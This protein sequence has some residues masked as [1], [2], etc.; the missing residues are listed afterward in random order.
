MSPRIVIATAASDWTGTAVAS[1]YSALANGV[2]VPVHVT[3]PPSSPG[4]ISS[5]L[6]PLGTTTFVLTVTPQAGTF[7]Q[8]TVSFTVDSAGTL[9]PE[10]HA[11]VIVGSLQKAPGTAFH[12]VTIILS[13]FQDATA[14][15]VKEL[16]PPPTNA[17][18]VA[19]ASQYNT[20]YGVFPPTDFTLPDRPNV[21]YVKSPVNGTTVEFA[22]DASV[23]VRADNVVLRLKG[24]TAP[25]LW[26][27]SWPTAMAPTKA[28]TPAPILLFIRQGNL[29]YKNDG[30][31][32]GTDLGP[33][34]DNFGYA[35]FGMYD[36][37]IYPEFDVLDFP[38]AKG[39]PYQVAKSKAQAVTVHPVNQ[40]TDVL[41]QD[42]GVMG[43]TEQT[44]AILLDLQ[45]FMFFRAGVQ[46]APK[47]IGTTVIAS[48]SSGAY[49]VAGWLNNADN[50]AGP[51]LTDTVSAVYFL[52]PA[53]GAVTESVQAAVG[54]AKA[55]R[56][57]KRVRF[58]SQKLWPILQTWIGAPIPAHTTDPVDT[59]V[60]N[61]S[62]G[63]TLAVVSPKGW[64]FLITAA[65]AVV[66]PTANNVFWGFT[67]HATAALFLSHALAQKDL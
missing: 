21:S 7:W 34:P 6:L 13:R 48:F 39:V 54:W 15:V 37:F 36:D 35:T 2:A 33:Y 12:L 66:P 59:F 61:T 22:T 16:T 5:F 67:H 44:A 49:V 4:P 24:V 29:Q 8:R 23:K 14:D 52:A 26:A 11:A 56:V 9:T 50:L 41:H 43:S 27:V 64:T 45:A 62:D 30:I 58:Y 65:G 32:T 17:Q 31:F 3:T 10:A 63:R 38:Y 18:A 55:P 40:L 53:D 1:T 60:M 57:D 19:T 51:F 42:F 47:T 20:N 28:L 46:A 25:Q